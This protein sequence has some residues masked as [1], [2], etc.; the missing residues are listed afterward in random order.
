MTA[1]AL[2]LLANDSCEPPAEQE[3]LTLRKR[4]QEARPTLEVSLAMASKCPP[5]AGQVA[6]VLV[7]RGV[8]EIVFVPLDL[9]HA[10]ELSAD[11]REAVH[12]VRR[13]H[14]DIRIGVARP[15]G[16]ATE[17]LNMLDR[18]LRTALSSQ[19]IYEL[20]GLVMSAAGSGDVRGRAL[21]ARRARQWSVHHKVPVQVAVADGSGPSVAQAIGSLRSQGR[22]HIAVGSMFLASSNCYLQQEQL[23]WAA[24]ARAVSAPLGDD[25][26]VADMILARY[27]FAAMELL[28][29]QLDRLATG[30]SQPK[31][32]TEVQ[33]DALDLLAAR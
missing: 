7:E 1:P 5:T 8:R 19:Q 13:H 3:L 11:S 6:S 30:E 23:A 20:D 15:V 10:V 25:E 9:E 31:D 32:T 24:G 17:L 14:P 4:M 18:A 27:A 33:F 21:L 26:L 29:E 12:T 16:P 22:R 28:D 2:I